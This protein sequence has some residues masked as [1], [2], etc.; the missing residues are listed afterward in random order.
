MKQTQ[1]L[2]AAVRPVVAASLSPHEDE[3][4]LAGS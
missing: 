3:A 1:D 4:F 2:L